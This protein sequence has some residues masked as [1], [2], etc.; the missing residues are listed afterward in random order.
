VT[1]ADLHVH[2]RASDGLFAPVEVV[3]RAHG[4][5]L[6][7][8]AL[9]DH[10][11]LAGLGEAQREARRIG[12]DFVPGCEISVD[13]DGRDIHL[14]AY[15]VDLAEP[16][17]MRLL[18]GAERMRGERVRGIL[19]RLAA[20]GLAL[21]EQDV[22]AEAAGS[23]AI[24]RLHVARALV[25]RRH[26]GNLAEAF[27]RYLGGGACAYV[28]KQTPSG[29]ET[30]AAV[31]ES[32]AVPVLAH[33]GLYGLEEPERFFGAWDLGGIE[34]N[35]PGHDRDAQE[36]FLRWAR[37]LGCVATGGSDWHGDERPAAYVGC[38]TVEGA[39]I[40]LLRAKRRPVVHGTEG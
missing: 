11:T 6:D 25:S 7:A 33:P 18:A 34:V 23:H 14:L 26:V 4:A 3:R 1:R 13:V 28:S 12:L 24:G 19:R 36:R 10:D 17:L 37:Q 9:T 32:G 8:L 22:R 31:W 2:S 27:L 20:A 30:L 5:G 15:F 16:R 40:E 39:V 38:R 35:H 29:P 21:D